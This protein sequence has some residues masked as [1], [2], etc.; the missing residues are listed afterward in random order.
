MT[1]L[2]YE[3]LLQLCAADKPSRVCSRLSPDNN[4]RSSLYKNMFAV[5]TKF[6]SSMAIGEKDVKL[7]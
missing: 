1:T 2:C 3:R 4:K 6:R 7:F 5:L